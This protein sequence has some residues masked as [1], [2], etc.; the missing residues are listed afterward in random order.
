MLIAPA[1]PTTLSVDAP[2]VHAP[3][4]VVKGLVKRRRGVATASGDGREGRGAAVDHGDGDTTAA[5][6]QSTDNDGR[7][8]D[9]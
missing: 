8:A 1:R 7:D 2:A 4:E 9:L 6:V 5:A 3:D